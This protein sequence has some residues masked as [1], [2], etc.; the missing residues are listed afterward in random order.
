[1]T[2]A[3]NSIGIT[4]RQTAGPTTRLGTACAGSPVLDQDP[5]SDTVCSP[6]RRCGAGSRPQTGATRS[7]QIRAVDGPQ[8]HRRA[9][10]SP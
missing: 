2:V 3:P 4:S 8:Q 10:K 7:R 9:L 1:M 6:H 5:R